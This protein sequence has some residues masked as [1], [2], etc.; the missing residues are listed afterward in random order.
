MFNTLVQ[1][2]RYTINIIVFVGD[3]HQLFVS[4]HNGMSF[5]NVNFALLIFN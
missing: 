3:L 5:I 2:Y 4:K 1:T